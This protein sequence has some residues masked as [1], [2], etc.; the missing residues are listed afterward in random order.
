MRKYKK[1]DSILNKVK[2]R[3]FNN[4]ISKEISDN[5]QNKQKLWKTFDKISNRK[6]S[7]KTGIKKLLIEGREITDSQEIANHLNNHFNEIG[8]KMANEIKERELIPRYV[9]FRNHQ[10]NHYI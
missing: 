9:I 5:L 6:K 2:K 10:F 4:H 1:Y 7:K 3:S 8:K